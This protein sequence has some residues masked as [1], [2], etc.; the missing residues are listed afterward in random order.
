MSVITANRLHKHTVRKSVVVPSNPLKADPSRTATLRRRFVTD[1]TKRF[2][3]LK[4]KILELV[5]EE[6][7]FGLKRSTFNPFTNEEQ[8][9][10]ERLRVQRDGEAE[11][12]IGRV[13]SNSGLYSY[14]NGSTSKTRGT[15]TL[16]RM[17]KAPL[18]TNQPNQEQI[19]EQDDADRAGTERVVKGYS[20][21]HGETTDGLKRDSLDITGNSIEGGLRQLSGI[22]VNQP[23]Q[24]WRFLSNPE[25][26]AAFRQW[27]DTQI[28]VD[29]IGINSVT[30]IDNAYWT[31]YVEE[32]YRKGAGRAFDDVRKPALASGSEQLSF[33]EGTK[34]EF[35]RQSFGR[36]ET[37]E[38][39]KLLAGRVF[40]D[41][42]GVTDVM[43]AQ[44]TRVL[45][46]G[47]VQGQNPREIARA[48]NQ[49]VDA[50]G[51]ARSTVIAR[52]E[53]IRAHAEGQLDALE[54]LGVAEVGVMVEWSTAGDDRVCPRCEPMDGVVLKIREARGLIPLHPQCRCAHIPANVGES[55]RGQTRSKTEIDKSIR[56]SVKAFKP[57]KTKRT[58]AQQ[59]Q[60][61]PFAGKTIAKRRPRSVLEPERQLIAPQGRPTPR[62]RPRPTPTPKPPP[63]V[64]QRPP[65]V[66]K[67]KPV[68]KPKAP[69]I[70]RKP[71]V[72]KAPPPTPKPKPKVTAPKPEP[73]VIL[74][75]DVTKDLNIRSFV[76]TG[77]EKQKLAA[78][79]ILKDLVEQNPAVAK[80]L[81]ASPL[82][83]LKISGDRVL[84]G[85]AGGK[86]TFG[87]T[88]RKIEISGHS[89]HKIATIKPR[90]G[91]NIYSVDESQ[92]GF[93]RHEVGHHLHISSSDA[94]QASWRAASR[95]SRSK[96]SKHSSN[97]EFEAFAES[98]SAYTHKGY[99]RGSLPTKVE[100]FMD[101]F[102]KVTN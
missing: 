5:V 32:G 80:K 82:T 94:T 51:K 10:V 41:L 1:V 91:N 93:L 22:T 7:A 24:R 4:G 8:D 52:T 64:K 101:D 69:P 36:P 102:L 43:A 73:K 44:M 38:K 28:Q 83:E 42:T 3:Q 74:P 59:K 66:T 98:F 48:L 20:N 50:I 70:K 57:K 76:S 56:E 19:G 27:L 12:T 13:S 6:D 87:K 99:V 23:N 63:P 33:F 18:T 21:Q 81:R 62:V 25:K 67:P 47:L 65:Q 68:I 100:S 37:I 9:N 95:G 40:T 34:Q 16:R 90:I 75:G 72:T 89:S 97:N 92:S 58:I 78:E 14:D 60:L 11:R 71:A 61:T 85:G 53:I 31:K 30:E 29:I 86:Y 46:D 55:T 79:N 77:T 88:T 49:R 45:T 2:F 96:I 39:V 15:R 17:A 54:Q 84:K 26:V 35:L